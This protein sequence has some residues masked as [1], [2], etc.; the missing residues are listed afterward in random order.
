MCRGSELPEAVLITTP[1]E[2]ELLTH[3]YVSPAPFRREDFAEITRFVELG[4]LKRLDSPNE[5]GATVTGNHEAL[6]VYMDALGQVPF[7]V[8]RWVV[9]RD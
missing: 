8:Q 3:Y 9:P 2:R 4:L 1:F 6:R 7:P 5:Y